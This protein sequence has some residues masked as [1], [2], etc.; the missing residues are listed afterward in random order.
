MNTKKF[1]PS[2]WV[3]LHV[4]AANYPENPTPEHKRTYKTFFTILKDI[5][6]CKHC[7]DSY[8]QFIRILPIDNYLENR[9]LMMYW[10]YLVHNMVNQ[11][12]RN[13]GNKITKDPLFKEVVRK[14]DRYRARRR[15]TNERPKG[16]QGRS[17][18]DD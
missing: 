5:L 2:L 15:K 17:P 14:Y 13:Q 6:P 18:K 3:S 7:R 8:C 11:K 12:L 16:V 4:F 9:T 10:L 1:G